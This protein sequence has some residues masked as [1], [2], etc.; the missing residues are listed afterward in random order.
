M[1]INM[2]VSWLQ[3]FTFDKSY[4][5]FLFYLLASVEIAGDTMETK[6]PSLV[7]EPET[8][9]TSYILSSAS[10]NYIVNP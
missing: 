2:I 8:L 4:K 9:R 7:S 5:D 3:V 6:E 10:L 1:S